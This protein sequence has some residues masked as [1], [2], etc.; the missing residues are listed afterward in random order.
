MKNIQKNI[1]QNH[2]TITKNNE[3]FFSLGWDIK[4]DKTV[5][6]IEIINSWNASNLT[7][8]LFIKNPI[9]IKF[10]SN[11]TEQKN[12]DK[13]RKNKK[14]RHIERILWHTNET[15]N[16]WGGVCKKWEICECLLTWIVLCFLFGYH[17]CGMFN[18]GIHALRLQTVDAVQH[19]P[20]IAHTHTHS[21]NLYVEFD[22]EKSK[23][24]N[25]IMKKKM[26]TKNVRK[27]WNR[28]FI[29][30]LFLFV[31]VCLHKLQIT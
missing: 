8:F 15:I 12:T 21:I 26:K 20:E 23:F 30:S 10:A 31:V 4:T 19:T 2:R 28:S 1:R 22:I 17:Q 29:C 11:K 24:R 5:Y 7:N 9:A 13:M 3:F 16:N 18:A 25:K 6:A 27:K 14:L